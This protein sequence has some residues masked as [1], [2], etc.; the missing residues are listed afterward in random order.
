MVHSNSKFE[1]LSGYNK[2]LKASLQQ[3]TEKN[4]NQPTQ[5]FLI[6]ASRLQKMNSEF[7]LN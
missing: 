7:A 1:A 4:R 5:W 3:E 2:L 6:V